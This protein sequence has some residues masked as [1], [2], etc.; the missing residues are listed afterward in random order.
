MNRE[1]VISKLKE[2]FIEAEL[3]DDMFDWEHE[4]AE[5]I[6]P[7]ENLTI[8]TKKVGELVGKT[9]KDLAKDMKASEGKVEGQSKDYWSK[10]FKE[11]KYDILKLFDKPK[12]IGICGNANE[13]KSM[14]I[15]HLIKELQKAGTFKMYSYSL[16]INLGEQKIY[17][18]E[19]LEKI[20]NSIIFCDEYFSLV[21][22]EDRKNRKSIEQTLRLIFHNNNILVLSGLPENFK[23]FISAK[24]NVMI[25]KR[26]TISEFI[27]GSRIKNVCLNYCGNELGSSMLDIS[28]DTALVFDGEHYNKIEIPYYASCDTK[29]KN[30]PIFVPRNVEKTC[31]KKK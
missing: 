1:Q 31:K 6:S 13:G 28:V 12:I 15:Y 16:R 17:S 23:K 2:K 26:T 14:L 8:L 10:C 24:I 19:E 29:T 3:G 9:I 30:V 7:E 5:D 22:L 4:Y 20:R 21:D 18:I 27:N 11:S 25:F